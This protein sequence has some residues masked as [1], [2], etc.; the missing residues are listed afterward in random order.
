MGL[1]GLRSG[2][3]EIAIWNVWGLKDGTMSVPR[4]VW[5]LAAPSPRYHHTVATC[6]L[7]LEEEIVF[8]SF[9][10]AKLLFIPGRRGLLGSKPL[11]IGYLS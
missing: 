10:E 4:A 5:V 2:W 11:M 6:A 7:E 1:V 9:G 8:S 3:F